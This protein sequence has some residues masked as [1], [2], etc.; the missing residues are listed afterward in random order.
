MAADV[1]QAIAI[2]ATGDIQFAQYSSNI[3]CLDIDSEGL[4]ENTRRVIKVI[5]NLWFSCRIET[6]N[7]VD[8]AR[9]PGLKFSSGRTQ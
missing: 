5:Q 1:E 6:V 7:A 8:A 4:Y 9:I 2:A 3:V